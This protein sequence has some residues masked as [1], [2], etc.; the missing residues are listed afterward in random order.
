[1]TD[2]IPR[3]LLKYPSRNRPGLFHQ[4]LRE[5][6]ADP[7]V[8][9]LCTLDNDDEA[10]NTPEMHAFLAQHED[11]VSVRWGDCKSKIEAVN[12]GLVEAQW[13]IVVVGG[14]DMVPQRPDYAQRIEELFRAAFPEGDGVL[15]LNDGRVGKKLNTICCCD[16]KYFDRRGHLYGEHYLSTWADNEFQ[17]ISESLHRAVYVDEVLL[18]HDWI[19][20]THPKDQLHRYNESFSHQDARTFQ[21]R[22]RAGFP[23]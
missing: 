14:D 22:K 10:M 7:I 21:Q 19:G 4:R 23:R 15:H 6:L 13:E 8:T 9:V 12:D 16:R 20:Q 3:V 18:K 11:R 2:S 17:A 1:M 5:Y